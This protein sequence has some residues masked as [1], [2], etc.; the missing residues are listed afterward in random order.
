MRSK[1]VSS[2]WKSLAWHNK[3]QDTTG[4]LLLCIFQ[5]HFLLASICN[6]SFGS[7]RC[8]PSSP[9]TFLSI[10]VYVY[11]QVWYYS[12]VWGTHQ[13]RYMPVLLWPLRDFLQAKAWGLACTSTSLCSQTI[14]CSTSNVVPTYICTKPSTEVERG[15]SYFT[16]SFS[17]LRNKTPQ[18][19]FLQLFLLK[20]HQRKITFVVQHNGLQFYVVMLFF[21]LLIIPLEN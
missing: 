20:L 2:R 10:D 9:L 21:L 16:S 1:H 7:F 5:H 3:Q 12:Q 6:L 18:T 13:M 4:A 14:L 8:C 19:T 15:S 17:E 11:I